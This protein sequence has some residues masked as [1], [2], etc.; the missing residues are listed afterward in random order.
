MRPPGSCSLRTG[1]EGGLVSV[2]G[3]SPCLLFYQPANQAVIAAFTRSKFSEMSTTIS[4]SPGR[5]AF[6]S[7]ALT[8]SRTPR[9]KSAGGHGLWKHAVDWLGPYRAGTRPATGSARVSRFGF[10]PIKRA[11]TE[12]ARCAVSD[13]L[14]RSELPAPSP[15]SPESVSYTHLRAHET[16]H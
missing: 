1:G 5:L 14:H 6:G 3:R 10:L 13:V 4:F 9:Q 12:C 15:A 7:M 11:R 2:W 16:R 8:M